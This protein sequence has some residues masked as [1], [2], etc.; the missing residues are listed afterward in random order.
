MAVGKYQFT[1]DAGTIEDRFELL[2]TIPLG[3]AGNV[4]DN[5]ELN[6]NDII[7]I[8]KYILG[9][10][11][12]NFNKI[13]ADYNKDGIITVIDIL[14]ILDKISATSNSFRPAILS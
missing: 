1:A 5:N 9:E 14:L 3:I 11:M 12:T 6:Y 7:A 4:D 10:T 13:N 2:V 8:M